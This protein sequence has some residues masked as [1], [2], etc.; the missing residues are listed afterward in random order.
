MK[1]K[2]TTIFMMIFLITFTCALIFSFFQKIENPAL[3]IEGVI[4]SIRTP[5]TENGI[6]YIASMDDEKDS[7]LKSTVEILIS[8]EVAEE[9]FE[10]DK[11]HQK[12]FTSLQRDA[13]ESPYHKRK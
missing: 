8:K 9:F 7:I 11:N 10:Y 3:S 1:K 4:I 12:Y 13:L 6:E 5:E 2:I